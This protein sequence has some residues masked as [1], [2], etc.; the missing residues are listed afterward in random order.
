MA[1]IP[2]AGRE[3][4]HILLDA[5]SVHDS[6]ASDDVNI[7]AVNLAWKRINEVD[8]AVE[9]HASGT[10]EDPDVEL[11]LDLSN[12]LGG[13]LIDVTWLVA[14]LAECRGSDSASI[15]VELREFLDA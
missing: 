4:A 6:S 11:S 2:A 15:I 12:V 5:V 3:V 10:D 13:A 14:R 9:A 8:G 1:D 7:D